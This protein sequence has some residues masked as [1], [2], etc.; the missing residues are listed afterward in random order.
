MGKAQNACSALP[1]R[2]PT[3]KTRLHPH[4]RA[5]AHAHLHKRR[6]GKRFAG[7]GG[8]RGSPFSQPTPPSLG[9]ARAP[10]PLPRRASFESPAGDERDKQTPPVLSGEPSAWTNTPAVYSFEA[11]GE[12]T[13]ADLVPR[14]S[15][16]A[17]HAAAAF[18]SFGGRWL[19]MALVMQNKNSG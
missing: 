5:R 8:W 12:E 6:E 9:R 15:S 18:R 13:L 2:A 11:T 3:V 14:W 7:G 1:W 16:T 17:V 10:P 19:L 4:T